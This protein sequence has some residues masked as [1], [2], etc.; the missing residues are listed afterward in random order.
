MK[1]VSRSICIMFIVVV[2]CFSAS[3]LTSYSAEDA[4]SE[5]QYTVN[6]NEVTIEHYLGSKSVV[7]VPETISGKKVNAISNSVFFQMNNISKIIIPKS[8]SYI[9]SFAFTYCYDLLTIEVAPDNPNYK[10]VDGVLYN[11]LMTTLIRYPE[12]K[13]GETFIVPSTITQINSFSFLNSVYVTEIKLP[14]NL[15]GIGE[16]AFFTCQALTTINLPKGITVIPDGAFTGCRKLKSIN[17][18]DGVTEI[19][20]D[21]FDDC[22]SIM[23]IQLPKNLKVLGGQHPFLTCNSLQSISIDPSNGF[24]ST[25][26]GVLFDK[27][28]T[29]L[30]RF[31]QD[32]VTTEYTIP[33]SVIK[34]APYAFSDCKKLSSVIIPDQT[35][36]LGEFSFW[37]CSGLKKIELSHSVAIIGEAVFGN[38]EKLESIELLEGL[39]TL[40]DGAFYEC[41][42]ENIKIPKSLINI[43]S[44]VFANCFQL[45]SF[46]VP[47]DHS[48]YASLDGVLFTKG[49][50]ELVIFP[51]GKEINSYTVPNS[52]NK[53]GDY[54]FFNCM[55]LNQIRL[56]DGIKSIGKG[57][58]WGCYYLKDMVIPE[59]ITLLE[60]TFNSCYNLKSITLPSTLTSM[61]DG[62][63]LGCNL[64]QISGYT[65]TF[66][67][68]YAQQNNINFINLRFIDMKGNEWYF[69]DVTSLVKAGIITGFP[70]G[71]FKSNDSIKVDQFIKTIICSLGYVIPKGEGYWAQNY[72]DKAR[73]LGLI[74]ANEFTTVASM[75]VD[76]TRCQ[77]AKICETALELLEGTKIYTKAEDIEKII[78]DSASVEA[79]GYDSYIYHMWEL[80]LITG[81]L[82]RS[83][84]PN[85]TLTRAEASTVIIRL[86]DPSKRKPF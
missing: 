17:I 74:D 25:E 44:N 4:S 75:K 71:Q 63:F 33:K 58:F 21:S 10:S 27:N 20:E 65:G 86:I 61:N 1:K 3:T 45:K 13:T 55:S 2:I 9:D 50:S 11:K 42:L 67:Q 12:S 52:V 48:V 66:V 8:V 78:S 49:L 29:T 28:K 5:F 80:G 15:T 70:D 38:C 30:I 40:G 62:V 35:V 57:A 51:P 53:I 81:Y 16:K 14:D 79:T 36:S 31:P 72:I 7:T 59:G 60:D 69:Q 34:I 37:T 46:D 24:Y 82:D 18:P 43:G 41:N 68:Q 64:E 22:N 19:G 39:T 76:I 84:K 77:M 73:E 83:F 6:G 26:N 54:A 47:E 32:H 23:N 56:Q 85:N